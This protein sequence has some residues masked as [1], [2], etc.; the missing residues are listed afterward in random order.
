M[1]VLLAHNRYQ[2]PGGEDAVFE[3]ERRLLAS[4]GHETT[5]YQRHNDE[6][7]GAGPLA[8]LRAATRTVWAGDSV[9]DLEELI[10]R[11]RPAVA[12]FVNTFPLISPAAYHVCREHRVPVVQAVGNYRLVCPSANLLRD[13]RLCEDCVGRTVAWPGVVHRCYRGSASASAVVAT[14]LLV[15][16]AMGT[17]RDLVDVYLAPSTLVANKLKEGGFPADRIMVRPNYVDPDPGER[18]GPGDYALFVGRLSPEKG[19]ETLLDAAALAAEVP[20]KIVGDGPLLESVQRAVRDERH[21]RIEHVG[22]SDHDDVMSLMRGARFLVFP[23]RCYEGFGLVIA[24]AFACGLPVIASRLGNM[25]EM[26]DDDATGLLFE[27]GNAASL[28]DACVRLWTNEADA[29]RMGRTARARFVS[30]YSRAHAAELLG[31]A[32]ER[33]RAMR[34]QLERN[35]T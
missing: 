11:E 2:R 1:R 25:A 8:L 13:G 7:H 31:E 23:S 21:G 22:W 29:E 18:R 4:L 35:R 34:G 14:M 26:V 9:R 15:H 10:V 3:M 17:F 27:P 16:H 32:Y 19:I 30:K 33:A 24:E 28:A 6:L 20:F 12:H 5:V